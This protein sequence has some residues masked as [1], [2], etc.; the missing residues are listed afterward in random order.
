MTH[1]RYVLIREVNLIIEKG[2]YEWEKQ[3]EL[4][5]WT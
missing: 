4:N 2:E 5:G 3:K 1:K